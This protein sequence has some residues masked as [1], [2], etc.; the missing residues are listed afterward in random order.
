MSNLGLRTKAA[1][2]PGAKWTVDCYFDRAIRW[3]PDDP[4]VRL[5]F[6]IHLTKRGQK[7]AARAQLAIAEQN[8]LDQASFHYNL[9]LAFLDVDD[10]ERALTHAW[11]AYALGYELPGLRHRLEKLGKWRDPEK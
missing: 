1:K 11:R 4:L 2:P 6:G 3:Q 5:V 7:D 10:A 9:G 8:L